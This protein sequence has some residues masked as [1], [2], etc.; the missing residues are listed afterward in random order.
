M[1]TPWLQA[2][3]KGRTLHRR[4][5][6]CPGREVFGWHLAEETGEAEPVHGHTARLEASRKEVSLWVGFVYRTQSQL[7]SIDLA[8]VELTRSQRFW[9]EQ[10]GKGHR[11]EGEGG[12]AFQIKEYYTAIKKNIFSKMT[13]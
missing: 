10:P 3:K 1:S 5:H 8:A 9:K 6:P 7:P 12:C 2:C 11:R 13:K 4:S